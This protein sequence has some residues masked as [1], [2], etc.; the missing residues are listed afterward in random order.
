MKRNFN[1]RAVVKWKC[2]SNL[3]IFHPLYW[4]C[5]KNLYTVQLLQVFCFQE[6]TILYFYLGT[7]IFFGVLKPLSNI[8]SL[9]SF[10]KIKSLAKMQKTSF[11]MELS[12]LGLQN[13]HCNQL[14]YLILNQPLLFIF[15]S[16]FIFL[17]TDLNQNF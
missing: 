11:R 14:L 12:V 1:N 13:Y 4:E 2:Y 8:H 6:C 10:S 9:N 15:F 16:S 17:Y 5:Y 7:C 3:D